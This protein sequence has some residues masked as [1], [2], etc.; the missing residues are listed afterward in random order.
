MEPID[1][2]L[3]LEDRNMPLKTRTQ[4]TD[5]LDRMDLEG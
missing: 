2:T 1:P 3:N 5:V 4:V